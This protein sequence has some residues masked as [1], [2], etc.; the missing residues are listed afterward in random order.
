MDKRRQLAEQPSW[1]IKDEIRPHGQDRLMSLG[2]QVLV[3]RVE[4]WCATSREPAEG[5]PAPGS[6]AR[7]SFACYLYFEVAIVLFA[8]E[9]APFL[10]WMMV[11]SLVRWGPGSRLGPRVR[12]FQTSDGIGNDVAGRA[13]QRSKEEI[14]ARQGG[15]SRCEDRE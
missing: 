12:A 5:E 1:S 8:G 6:A 3:P 2:L 10:L 9:R 4:M 7:R 14:R 13:R 15:P 11:L